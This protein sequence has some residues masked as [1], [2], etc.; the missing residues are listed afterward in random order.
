V[1][2]LNDDFTMNLEAYTPVRRVRQGSSV[3]VIDK[4]A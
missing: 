2:F 3:P 4:G 1:T